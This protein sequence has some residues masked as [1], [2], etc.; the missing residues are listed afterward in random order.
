MPGPDHWRSRGCGRTV[1]PFLAGNL[2][3]CRSPSPWSNPPV[4]RR[5]SA[6]IPQ[7]GRRGCTSPSTG[8]PAVHRCGYSSFTAMKR[9]SPSTR[10]SSRLT[11]R[12]TDRPGREISPTSIESTGDTH[13]AVRRSSAHVR[14]VDRGWRF[15]G[16][17]DLDVF[18]AGELKQC[19]MLVPGLLSDGGNPQ[20]GT[21]PG[22]DAIALPADF[23]DD[24]QREAI[25]AF[26]SRTRRCRIVPT[27]STF[28]R[29]LRN[30][31]PEHSQK[32]PGPALAVRRQ[33][34]T[35]CVGADRR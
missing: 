33:G 26:R 23:P 11:I 34:N 32:R 1:S 7:T 24:Q 15:P 19:R 29:I 6:P 12:P 14:N 4:R 3:H 27:E 8:C 16:I 28:C 25:G 17:R 5:G 13:R 22:R 10:M 31:P 2:H 21:V 20:V 30:L 35:R 9:I 18:P